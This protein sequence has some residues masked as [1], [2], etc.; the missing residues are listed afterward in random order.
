MIT[1]NNIVTH[2]ERYL[3]KYIAYP[4]PYY[5][6]VLT[7]WSIATHCFMAFDSFPYLVI[8]GST[9]RSGKS[10]CMEML[11]FVAH[12]GYL[13]PDPTPSALYR[14]IDADSPTVF[15]DE[16]EVLNSESHPLRV[17]LNTGYRRGQTITRTVGQTVMEF[18]TYCPKVFVLIGDVYDTLRDRS[19]QIIMQRREAPNRF[20]FAVAQPDGEA[21]REHVKQIIEQTGPE[22]E[23]AYIEFP[24]L[25]YLGDRE[26]ECWTPLFILCQLL[27]PE[28][29]IELQRAAV[30][31]S[32]EKTADAHRWRDMARLETEAQE[33]EYELRL[34][35]DCVTVSPPQNGHKTQGHISTAELIEKLKELPTGPWRKF[36]GEGISSRMLSQMLANFG[37]RPALHRAPKRSA[38]AYGK[39][40]RGYEAAELRKALHGAEK[41]QGG[42]D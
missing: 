21:L 14:K 19:I 42:G 25:L 3:Q 12:E 35:R 15:M 38:G 32:A 7:L 37:I 40:A 36:K 9:K 17:L 22:I 1:R 41:G 16:A 18:K 8:T 11:S 28:R 6:F 27:C 4:E 5:A 31:M 23:K 13:R 33:R 26:E 30:D 34:L 20:T 24:G 39:V 10:R 29:L 2:I